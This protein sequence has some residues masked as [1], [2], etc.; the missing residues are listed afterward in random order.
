[1]ECLN[2]KKIEH[3]VDTQ[4]VAHKAC[5]DCPYIIG[6]SMGDDDDDSTPCTYAQE[7]KAFS[8]F[9]CTSFHVYVCTLSKCPHPHVRSGDVT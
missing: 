6:D 4:E 2:K 9:S 1:M 8:A 5:L 3:A 7:K